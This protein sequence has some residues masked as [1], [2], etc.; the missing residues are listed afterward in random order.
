VLKGASL[1]TVSS[2]SPGAQ[3]ASLCGHDVGPGDPHVEPQAYH[4]RLWRLRRET[5][6]EAL[7]VVAGA[8]LVAEVMQCYSH[9]A[10]T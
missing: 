6:G 7:G 8:V 2:A 1:S 3:S 10:I 4:L 5:Q 9:Q